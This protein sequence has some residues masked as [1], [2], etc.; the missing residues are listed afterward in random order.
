MVIPFLAVAAVLGVI[1]ALSYRW[2][3]HSLEAM[4]A[5]PRKPWL[6]LLA[7]APQFTWVHWLSHLGPGVEQ[8]AWILP[9]SYLPVLGFI[10]L[11]VRLA[12]A[13]VVAVGVT[14]N[15]A[16]MLANGGTMPAPARFATSQPAITSTDTERL[17]PG[18]KDRLMSENAP[19]LLAPLQDQYVITLPNG[20][21]H[22][23]SIG[24]FI[25]LGGAV[26]GL[27]STL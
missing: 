19:P 6:L 8:F 20:T 5:L 21:Q 1:S 25:S 14:L 2:R 27:V 18:T 26:F 4:P 23:T 11:N 17:A 3:R 12:W 15:L 16:V 22:V 9:L 7:I 13:R 10:A 24:D